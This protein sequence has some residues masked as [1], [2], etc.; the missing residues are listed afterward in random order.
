MRASQRN[1]TMTARHPAHLP[2]TQ[3]NRQQMLDEKQTNSPRFKPKI[4]TQIH[5]QDR[6]HF[7]RLIGSEFSIPQDSL[8]IASHQPRIINQF[9]VQYCHY[10]NLMLQPINLRFMFIKNA[11]SCRHRNN[12]SDSI[13]EIMTSCTIYHAAAHR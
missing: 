8:A 2:H 13:N 1:P 11:N 7:N 5:S 12:S 6:K 3:L 4:Q 9:R 10:Q